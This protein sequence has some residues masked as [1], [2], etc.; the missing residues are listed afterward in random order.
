MASGDFLLDSD[1][2]IDH[3]RGYG[4]AQDFLDSLLQQGATLHFSVV[5]EAEI[6]SNVRT[7]EVEAVNALF[8]SM[9]R[10]DLTG[11]IARQ[12]GAYRNSFRTKMRL[13]LPDAIIAATAL[14]CGAV[15]VTRNVRHYPMHNIEI[16]MPYVI[17]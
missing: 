17:S 9:K 15:L 10:V 3:L 16:V 11:V 2:L 4:P 6:Y 14:A 13:A 5:T 7:G 1:V 12:A 8:E